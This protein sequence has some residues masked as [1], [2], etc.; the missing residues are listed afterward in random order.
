[1]ENEKVFLD[2]NIVADIIDTTRSGHPASSKLLETLIIGSCDICIS[3]DMLST[4][5]YISKDKEKT[6]LFFENIVYIDWNILGF[7]MEVIQKATKLSLE[8][9][10]DFEDILQCLCAKENDCSI[11]ITNDKKF[12]RCGIEIFSVETFLAYKKDLHNV[13]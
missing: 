2:I 6:L 3:E 1:M 13:S 5:Y 4:L 10:Q 9:T 7:G 11:F 8:Q 12:H